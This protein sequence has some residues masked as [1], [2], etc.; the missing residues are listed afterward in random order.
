ME[1]KR[2][3]NWRILICALCLILIFSG[4]SIRIY[5]IQTVDAA[6]IMGQAQEQW[7]RNRT[8][9]PTRGAIKDRNG[10]ILAFQGKAYT[11]N[12]S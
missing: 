11:V 3:V 10:E 8:L 7:D 2:L 6:R 9:Q 4:L 5:W 1:T 12:A